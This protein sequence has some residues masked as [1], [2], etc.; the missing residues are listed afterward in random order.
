MQGIIVDDDGGGGG[1]CGGGGGGGVWRFHSLFRFWDLKTHQEMRE[2]VLCAETDGEASR[3]VSVVVG[4]P[5][6]AAIMWL[7]IPK[8]TIGMVIPSRIAHIKGAK[9]ILCS[10]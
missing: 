4:A 6:S 7:G 5:D 8:T 10:C 9:I 1:G 2:R 3:P